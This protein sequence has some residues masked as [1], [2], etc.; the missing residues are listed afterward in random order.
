MKIAICDDEAADLGLIQR[1]CVEYDASLPVS[2]FAS[3]EELIEAFKENFYDLVFLDIELGKL[4]GL[5]VGA[6]LRGLPDKPIII[7]TT[8][9][10]NYAVRGY[11]IAMRY[12]PKP[13][14]YETF[15]TVM[16]EALDHITPSKISICVSGTQMFFSVDDIVYFEVLRHQLMVHLKDQEAVCLRGTLI[17]VIEQ[18][19]SRQ[20]VQPHKSYYVNMEYIDRLTGQDIMMTNGDVIPVGRSKKNEFKARLREYI[21]GNRGNEYLD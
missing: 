5:E 3:G 16:R 14:S 13:I 4:S 11:G 19:P 18:I 15:S 2:L 10:L 21:K 12:L 6:T 7:F 1:Y 20:F 8:H 9:S 17:E